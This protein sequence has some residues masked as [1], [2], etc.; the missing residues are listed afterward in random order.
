[1]SFT[2]II[3]GGCQ[4]SRTD[5][6]LNCPAVLMI[7]GPRMGM[8]AVLM[9]CCIMALMLYPG[10]CKAPLPERSSAAAS[11]KSP[12][13]RRLQDHEYQIY[14]LYSSP[15]SG[16]ASSSSQSTL[17]SNEPLAKSSSLAKEREQ[18][19]EAYNLL[20]TLAQVTILF[21]ESV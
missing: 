11:P 4:G 8:A 15:N 16:S 20:H 9:I 3:F 10:W 19:Y 6:N 14:S 5:L 13:Q 7:I 17:D 21:I 18:L 12:L 1:M 2:L